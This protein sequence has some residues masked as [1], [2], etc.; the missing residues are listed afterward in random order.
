[1]LQMTIQPTKTCTLFASGPTL[2]DVVQRVEARTVAGELTQSTGES[3]VGAIKS[4]GDRQNTPLRMIDAT[5]ENLED[6][7]PKN[8]FDPRHDPSNTSYNLKRRRVA[9]ALKE[10]LGIHEMLQ[11]L[12][13][14]QDEWTDLFLVMEPYTKFKSGSWGWHPM[15][16]EAMRSFALVARAHGWQPRDIN[17]ARATQLDDLY[18]G[19]KRTANRTCL[20]RLDDI[21]KF[22]DALPFLPPE[23]IG[24]DAAHRQEIKTGFP[25]T[26]DLIFNRWIDAVTK[27]GWDPVAEANSDDRQKHAHVLR[28]AFR[29]FFRIALEL[30]LISRDAMEILTVLSCDEAIRLVAREMFARKN[31]AREKGRLDPRTSRKYLKGIRQVLNARG[32]DT[33]VLSR[34]IANNKDS[35]K[36]AAADKRMTRQNQAFCEALVEKLHLRRRF[37]FSYKPLRAQAEA[38]MARAKA[39]ARKMTKNEIARVRLLGTCACF[40]AIEI[41]GAPIRVENAMGLSCV[42]TD[43]QILVPKKGKKPMNVLIPEG[44]TKNGVEIQFPIKWNKHGCYDTIEWYFDTI[45][46]LFPYAG[47]NPYLFPAVRAVG[48]PMDPGYFGE[49][50]SE[51]M[52]T[53]VDLPMTPHQMRHGQT[54]LLLNAHP[55]EIEVIAKRIDDSVDTLRRYYGWLNAMRMVE[56]GQ[57]LLA[58]LMDG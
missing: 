7:L 38:I 42:G 22:S 21:R 37:L 31:R 10:F 54:S 55:E 1:M 27:S 48:K 45:R 53:I 20:V 13:A 3:Y 40:A 11:T 18:S 15:C 47:S 6:V 8:G 2:A 34:I 33:T 5:L 23:P 26:F 30:D 12:R 41:G 46:P 24:F 29:C 28:S 43:A 58:G 4:V 50:F 19:N 39:E 16:L 17:A 36:G 9:A 35:R 32:V 44:F 57:D 14:Q 51:F 56:R 25:S 49:K 52:R